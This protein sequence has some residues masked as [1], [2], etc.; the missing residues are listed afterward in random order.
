[1][2][3]PNQVDPKSC[4]TCGVQEWRQNEYGGV[5]T[6]QARLMNAIE[7][8][9]MKKR[10]TAAYI[11]CDQVAMAAALDPRSV[12]RATAHHVGVELYGRHTRGQMVVDR[13]PQRRPAN[14]HLIEEI[15]VALFRT[16]M[17]WSLGG[18]STGYVPP[19]LP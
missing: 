8:K 5:A 9:L 4:P 13:S 19:R 14:V 16:M 18:G 1:M 7:A 10:S 3:S 15:D 6:E 12:A 11:A 17:V 2:I